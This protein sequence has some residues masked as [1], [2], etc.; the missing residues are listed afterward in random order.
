MKT[1]LILSRRIAF[2]R[3]LVC[4]RPGRIL[5]KLDNYFTIYCDSTADSTMWLNCTT[6]LNTDFTE[7]FWCQTELQFQSSVMTVVSCVRRAC[8][9][10]LPPQ[11]LLSQ[12]EVLHCQTILWLS[13]TEWTL[14]LFT[15][16]IPCHP[17]HRETGSS[18]ILSV[19]HHFLIKIFISNQY[20]QWELVV[21]P[22]EHESVAI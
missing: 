21:W 1:S 2:V 4:R 5:R 14:P 19:M 9:V 11:G 15:S 13:L 3:P 10:L 7:C 22:R 16:L 6:F 18:R 17:S 8:R 20:I 12:S